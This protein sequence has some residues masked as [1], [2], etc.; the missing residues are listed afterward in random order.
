MVQKDLESKQMNELIGELARCYQDNT[1]GFIN[2]GS[3]PLLTQFKT[4]NGNPFF[5]TNQKMI[6]ITEGIFNKSRSIC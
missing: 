5:S 3:N 4:K 6:E 1:Y 2:L